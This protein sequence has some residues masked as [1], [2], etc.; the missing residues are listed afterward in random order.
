M[1]ED[2][3]SKAL[4]NIIV[5]RQAISYFYETKNKDVKNSASYHAQQAIELVIKY[6]IYNT[7]YKSNENVSQIITHDL[8]KLIKK[9]CVPNGIYVP[10][11]IKRKAKVYTK[12]EV[13]S[14]YDLHYSVRADSINKALEETEN[15]LIKLKP[16]Y[17]SK[18]SAIHKRY[19]K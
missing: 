14:R 13:E 16:S 15:W 8:D 11:V 17:K 5:A 7:I 9:Y 4:S 12:W 10:D 18:I 6:C 3:L 19:C 2:Y 1:Y